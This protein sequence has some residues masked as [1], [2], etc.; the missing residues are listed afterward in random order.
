MTSLSNKKISRSQTICIY[1]RWAYGHLC[2]SV[3]PE[4]RE[5]VIKYEERIYG[6]EKS[7]CTRV[8]L[9][10]KYYQASRG[11]RPPL[12]LSTFRGCEDWSDKISLS[13]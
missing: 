2:F 6:R 5:W 1:C 4:D 13:L 9:E 7:C 10:C 12:N 11:Y 3:P 8:V